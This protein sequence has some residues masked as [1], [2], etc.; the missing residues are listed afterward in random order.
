MGLGFLA[1]GYATKE[2]EVTEERLGVYLPVEH[3]DNPKGYAAAEPGGDARRTD[4]RLRGPIDPRELEIDPNTG[5]KVCCFL[6][7]IVKEEIDDN[8]CVELHRE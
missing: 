4:A 2:F 7:S 3:I 5:M 1:H 6:Y 8:C